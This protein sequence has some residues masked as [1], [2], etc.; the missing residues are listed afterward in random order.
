MNNI[1]NVI[2][3]EQF[4]LLYN[5]NKAAVY[6]GLKARFFKEVLKYYSKA[7]GYTIKGADF[8]REYDLLGDAALHDDDLLLVVVPV[9]QEDLAAGIK[10]FKNYVDMLRTRSRAVESYYSP[11]Q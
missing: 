5:S 7:Q 6:V 10:Y 11:A 8:N 2:S 1:I 4:T 9:E 3:S